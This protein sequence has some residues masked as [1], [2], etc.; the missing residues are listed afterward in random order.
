MD[1]TTTSRRLAQGCLYWFEVEAALLDVR[2]DTSPKR[3]SSNWR[4]EKVIQNQKI[5]LSMPPM[6]EATHFYKTHQFNVRLNK[7]KLHH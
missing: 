7:E 6:E 2:S 4:R 3:Y 1:G 5:T